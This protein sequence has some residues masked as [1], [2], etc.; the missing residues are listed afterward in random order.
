MKTSTVVVILVLFSASIASAQES[1][2]LKSR[3]GSCEVAVPGSWT[4]TPL[5]GSGYSPDK[6]V[7]LTLNS[8]KAIESFAELKQ[9]A[10][11]TYANSKVTKDSANSKWKGDPSPTSLT[12]TALSRSSQPSSA[13]WK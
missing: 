9:I 6:K 4:V 11:M 2:T 1:Q 7:T 3:D 12:S 5:L 13:S 8:P 10:K